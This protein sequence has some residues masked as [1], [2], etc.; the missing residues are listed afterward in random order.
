MIYFFP[1]YLFEILHFKLDRNF[2][3]LKLGYIFTS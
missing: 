2:S 3:L 1:A